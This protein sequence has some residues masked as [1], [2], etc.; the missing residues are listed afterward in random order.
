MV[1]LKNVCLVSTSQPRDLADYRHITRSVRHRFSYHAAHSSKLGCV[2]EIIEMPPE[3]VRRRPACREC[4]LQKVSTP[5]HRGHPPPMSLHWPRLTAMGR[6]NATPHPPALVH[7]VAECSWSA[8]LRPLPH[9]G[10][11]SPSCRESLKTSEAVP[12]GWIGMRAMAADRIA[13]QGTPG[14]M[15]MELRRRLLLLSPLWLQTRFRLPCLFRL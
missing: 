13:P 6:S 11:P 12:S 1:H 9:L 15:L 5:N 3:R 8:S 7:D 4:R 10:G 14:S 2:I